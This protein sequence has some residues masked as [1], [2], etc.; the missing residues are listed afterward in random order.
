[1]SLSTRAV[2]TAALATVVA[3]AAYLGPTWLAV[4]AVALVVLLAAGWP[5]L[6]GLPSPGYTR[7][8]VALGGI[9]AVAVTT[10]TR[11]EPVLRH[12]PIVLAMSVVLAFLAEMLRR[13]GRT[14]LVD[15]VS[16][17]V[18]GAVV[19]TACAAWV[20][21]GRSEAGAALVVTCAVA[22]AVAAAVSALPLGAWGASA[23]AVGAA[24]VAGGAAGAAMPRVD[25]TSGIWS[26]VV[27]GLVVAA[28]HLLFSHLPD[29]AGRWAAWAA[30]ALPVAVGGILV[31][32]VGRV[33][34][35]A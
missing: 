24:V 18:S 9:G 27:A 7:L 4:A 31:F 16:G 28:L 23:A 26:G 12:L 11:G 34:V 5:D 35:V 29:R 32:V 8:V 20:A 22:L 10:F 15:S 33:V 21:V 3:A 30:V 19:A 1:M 6:L 25:V 2:A 17:T 14:R 13:D